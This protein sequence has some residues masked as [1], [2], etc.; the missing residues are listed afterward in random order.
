MSSLNTAVGSLESRSVLRQSFVWMTLGLVLTAMIAWFVSQTASLAQIVTAEP[1]IAIVSLVVWFILGLGFGFIVRRVPFIVGLLLFIA[2]SAFTGLAFSWI[3]TAYT[4]ATIAY[5]LAST[6]GL[7]VIATVFAL[8]TKIDLTRW[9]THIIFGILG[10]GLATVLNVLVFQSSQFDLLL[11]VAGVGLFT[12]STAA[13]VQKIIAL[14]HELDAGLHDRIAIIGA[15]MLYT[16]FINL[17][18]RLL[19]LYSRARK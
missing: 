8:V 14:E 4:E 15:M 12:I 5:A 19:R 11:S 3:F 2:Y 9:W 16:N 18:L 1:V 7:F 6:V 10:I 13:T 17:F